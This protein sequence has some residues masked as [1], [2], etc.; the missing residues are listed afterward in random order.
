MFK[1]DIHFT[2]KITETVKVYTKTGEFVC[3]GELKISPKEIPSVQ[4]DYIEPFKFPKKSTHFICSSSHQT[5]TLIGCNLENGIAIYPKLIIKGTKKQ[6]QFRKFSILLHG[7]SEWMDNSSRFN[8][9]ETEILKKREAKTFKV[10]IKDHNN[11]KFTISSKHWCNVEK[12]TDNTQTI[13]QRTIITYSIKNGSFSAD[14]VLKKS[15]EIQTI[16]TLLLGFSTNIEY[17]W[18]QEEKS[19]PKSIY[20]VNNS[21]REYPYKYKEYCLTDSKYLFD[22]N[23]WPVIFKKFYEEKYV[24]FENLWARVAGMF[25][26]SGFWEFEILAY[27]SLIDRVTFLFANKNKSI[28]NRKQFLRIQSEIKMLIKNKK[29]FTDQPSPQDN[30]DNQIL[31]SLLEQ[32]NYLKNS[33]LNSFQQYFDQALSKIDS[34]IKDIINL[35]PEQFAHLKKLRNQIAHGDTPKLNKDNNLTYEY[36]LKS[37]LLILLLYWIYRDF[38]FTDNDF[39]TF[40]SNW[41]HPNVREAYLNQKVIDRFFGN[42]HYFKISNTALKTIKTSKPNIIILE[43]KPSI[44]R[45]VFRPEYSKKAANIWKFSTHNLSYEGY[46]ASIIDPRYI[47]KVTYANNVYLESSDEQYKIHMGICILNGP[48]HLIK[49]NRTQIYDEKDNQW[50]SDLK[51]K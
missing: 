5:Y 2:D 25:S 22:N 34:N 17:I 39:I 6:A 38:G 29:H 14:E 35:T 49:S 47:K 10:S 44:K 11:K 40:I 7:I 51:L 37:K 36:I 27:V 21:T 16:F 50:K 45:Y 24:N 1:E 48:K 32:I 13:N 3:T 23:K 12:E 31:D 41:Q 28:M 26:Y 30:I 42:H 18:D 9:S 15:H 43:Y 8:I 19:S 4:V 33:D 20:F 46:V